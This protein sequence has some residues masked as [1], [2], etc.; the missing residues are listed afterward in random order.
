MP[1]GTVK[2]VGKLTGGLILILGILQPLVTMN[3]ED[4]YDIVNTIP[5]HAPYTERLE[6]TAAQ[7]LKRIIEAEL[8]SYI[9]DKG[10]ELGA[11]CRA[12]VICQRGEGGV[13]IPARVTVTG[14]LTPGQKEALIRYVGEELGIDREYQIYRSEGTS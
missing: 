1:E 13:P 12:E 7:P 4:L 2:R 11:D 14:S 9:V 8:A 10:A 3:Y 6:E 5:A